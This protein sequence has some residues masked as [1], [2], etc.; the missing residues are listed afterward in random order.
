MPGRRQKTPHSILKGQAENR[1]NGDVT[2]A[3]KARVGVSHD[4]NQGYAMA[5]VGDGPQGIRRVDLPVSLVGAVGPGSAQPDSTMNVASP[6]GS[7]PAVQPKGW[8]R[9][10]DGWENTATWRTSVTS[11]GGHCSSAASQGTKLVSE[12][13][14]TCAR[15]AAVG[16]RSVPTRGRCGNFDVRALDGTS[17]SPNVVGN[18]ERGLIDR[19]FGCSAAGRFRD[20]VDKLFAESGS[21][22]HQAVSTLETNDCFIP[23]QLLAQHVTIVEIKTY[24]SVAHLLHNLRS[25]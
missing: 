6:M 12:S 15:C 18:S 17:T 1:T 20:S 7:V 25:D 4:S 9:T 13:A 19:L 5:W 2:V 16:G 10:R 3:T 14:C 22:F 23:V 8:R 21:V 24:F 11:L